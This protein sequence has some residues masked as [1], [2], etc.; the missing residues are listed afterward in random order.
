MKFITKVLKSGRSSAYTGP[1]N[2]ELRT[3]F[4]WL[5]KKCT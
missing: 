1:Q 2:G 5:L 3:L 4:S